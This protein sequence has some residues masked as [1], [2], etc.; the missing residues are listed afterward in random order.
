M[1]YLSIMFA[2][3]LSSLFFSESAVA[4]DQSSTVQASSEAPPQ[5]VQKIEDLISTLESEAD[6]GALVEKLKLLLEVNEP[7]PS[8]SLVDGLIDLDSTGNGLANELMRVLNSYGFSDSL[9]GDLLVLLVA[10]FVIGVFVFLNGMLAVRLEKRMRT[11]SKRLELGRDRFQ[12]LFSLQRWAGYLFGF[13]VSL[14][15]CTNVLSDYYPKA[16]EFLA[17]ES[18][19]SS[20]FMLI[21]VALVF[22][23]IWEGV[24]AL[25]E[26][27][28]HKN[29][30][31]SSSRFQTITPIIRNILMFTLSLLSTMVVL[32]E[33]G[34]DIMPLLAGAG[35][36]GIAVGFGA[37][38]LVKDFLTGLTVIFEDLLQIGDVIQL[39]DHFGVVEKISL[40]KIQIRDLDGAV[41]TVPFGDISVVK[42]LT[43]DFSFA[44]F[45]IGVAYRENIDDVLVCL[46][47]IDVDLRND[48]VY[49]EK[50]LE[51]MEIF[52]LD[53]FAGS[54]VMIKARIKTQ[55]HDRWSVMREYNRRM[56][57]A[58]DERNIEIPFPHQTIYFGED[59]SGRAP[60]AK[61]ELDKPQEA[62]PEV[63]AETKSDI[64][65]STEEA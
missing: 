22:M 18:V 3:L 62:T 10:L 57:I 64:K 15:A 34:I 59:K 41:I 56:K 50:I 52:G 49:K 53:Q 20:A 11:I 28:V 23:L 31:L 25:L 1:R 8:D 63:K 13:I 29:S 5:E 33:L 27:I 19:F 37:Q 17:F 26:L 38:T 60:S 48:D 36:L 43:K 44:L 21:V 4:A 12:V 58:F 24:N 45:N 39:G 7:V 40:R 30:H 47:E 32:S 65:P 2:V 42:N 46:K 16:A 9:I 54:A 14:Y 6:R 51:P 35:V 61:I 55:S